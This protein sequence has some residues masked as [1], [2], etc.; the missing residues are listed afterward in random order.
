MLGYSVIPGQGVLAVPL[1][2]A[3]LTLTAIGAGESDLF[4]YSDGPKAPDQSDS[5][6]EVREY[7]RSLTGFKS[8]TVMMGQPSF[9]RSL[10]FPSLRQSR[11]TR[12]PPRTL[13]LL[14]QW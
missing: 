14:W 6:R 7:L 12:R 4:V 3:G 8:V 9:L 10:Q 1:L 2:F 11:Q 13:L 5:V